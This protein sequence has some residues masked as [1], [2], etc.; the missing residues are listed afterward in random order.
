MKTPSKLAII[1]VGYVGLPLAV[2]FS[3]E[4][5]VVAYDLSER[6]VKELRSGVDRT[7]EV[8]S[9]ELSNPRLTFTSNKDD[10]KN[11]SFYI[12]TVPTPVDRFNVPDMTPL[13]SACEALAPV[14][15][16]GAI[17]VFES[18]VYPGLS[19][20]ELAPRLEKL[21]GMKYNKDFFFG[22]SPERVNPGDKEHTIPKIKKIVSGSTPEVLEVVAETYGKIIKA[23]IHRAPNIATAEAAKVIENIQRDVNIGLVNELAVLFDR[24]GL[25][26]Y[27][28]LAASGTKWNF[29][30]F[31]PGLVGGH[32]IGVDPFYLTHKANSIGFNAEM[33][34][35]GRRTNDHMADF[36]SNK[37][38]REMLHR[39]ITPVGASVLVLGFTF[40]ENCP[41]VRNTKVNDL[42][43]ALK[44]YDLT[45]DAVDPTADR[46]IAHH[47]YG[48]DLL[49]KIPSGKKYD[50]VV[51]AVAHKELVEL[52]SKGLEAH[53]KPGAFILDIKGTLKTGPSVIH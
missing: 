44:R 50:A 2:C 7:N 8:E 28:V 40:K 41:D 33:I 12:V 19:E 16:K 21:T 42:V 52:A 26:I 34:L 4:L 27:E 46:E 29:L 39:K 9:H 10:L 43:N 14:L 1:G 13:I 48:I 6:R 53:L 5:D 18:T 45:V 11:I 36:F 24:M 23:G 31:R 20:E 30:P 37:C 32:C 35:A 47:E 49:E 38:L 22:Y 15:T 3:K 25:D 17:V 51:F